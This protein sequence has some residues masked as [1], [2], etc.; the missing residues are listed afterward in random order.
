VYVLHELVTRL[1]VA[2]ETGLCH[3]RAVVERTLQILELR[4]I[5]GRLGIGAR[6]RLLDDGVEAIVH[7]VVARPVRAGLSHYRQQ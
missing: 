6:G 2:L 7:I 3:F 1:G 4:V 5:R